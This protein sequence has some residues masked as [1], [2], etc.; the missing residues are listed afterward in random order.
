MKKKTL[1]FQCLL[2]LSVLIL[3]CDKEKEVEIYDI[4]NASILVIDSEKSLRNQEVPLLLK[5]SNNEDYTN[6]ATFYVNGNPIEGSTF[7]SASE[8]L[9][10]IYAEYNLAG[11]ISATAVK[12]VEVF[13]PKRKVLIEDYTGT[14]C[15]NCPRMTT[16]VHEAMEL[17]DQ[18]A[19]IS[20]HGNSIFT[21]VDPLTI[22]EGMFLKNY[23]DVPGYPW[24]IINRAEV[25]DESDISNQ[26]NLYAGIDA[27]TSI[28]VKSEL[29]GSNLDVEISLLSE[30]NLSNK[31]LVVYLLEDGILIDQVNYYDTDPS[32]PWY[33]MGNP[34]LNFQHD[35]VLRMLLTEP[36][37]DQIPELDALKIHSQNFKI[38]VPSNFDKNNLSL[39]AFVVNQDDTTIN[40]QFARINEDKTFE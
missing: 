35:H 25:W 33:Q 17:T 1:V 15:G 32:S 40:T 34:I 2:L 22:D 13:I 30:S 10:E 31:K 21:G 36:L 9:F 12:T 8:G 37:G 23:F 27:A 19:V 4:N 6:L 18:V 3:S 28:G 5:G 11:T 38:T 39:V 26:L 7:S 16:F 14:W 24:G 29:T 20:I